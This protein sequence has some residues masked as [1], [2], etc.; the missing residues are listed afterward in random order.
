MER[1]PNRP[2]VPLLILGLP[3]GILVLVFIFVLA[4]LADMPVS[5]RTKGSVIAFAAMAIIGA[6]I[7]DYSALRKRRSD[8]EPRSGGFEWR[9]LTYAELKEL[10]VALPVVALALPLAV[11]VIFR[12]SWFGVLVGLGLA[13]ACGLALSAYWQR[14]SRS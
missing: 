13:F 9:T 11:M 10:P 5:G 7:A 8:D 14:G 2:Y 4:P 3:L 6:A 1:D 12:D